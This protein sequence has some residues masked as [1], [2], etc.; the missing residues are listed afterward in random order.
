MLNW[1]NHIE[2]NL[3]VLYGKP[4]V[5]NSRISVDI[6]LEKIAFGDSIQDLLAAYPTLKIE[7]IQSCLLFASET[8]KNEIVYLKAS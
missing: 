5:K 1:Q 4:V 3:E 2:S 8:I 6:I 7:D